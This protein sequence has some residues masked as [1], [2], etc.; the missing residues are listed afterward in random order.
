MTGQKISIV[1]GANNGIGFETAIGMA[2]AGFTVILACRNEAKALAA[3]EK[4]R[5]R[6]P[7][8]Q[9]DVILLDLS[10]FDSV[11]AFADAFGKKYDHLDV[12]INNA[13]VLDYSGRTNNAGIELQFAT[14]HLGHFLLT[15]L[16]LPLM[17]DRPASRIVSLSSVAHKAG[18][19][20]FDDIQCQGQSRK[21]AA[22][23][24]SKL[25]CLMFADELAR[26]LQKSG[27]KIYSLCAHPGGSDSG[28]FEDMARLH[29]Y[30]LKALGPFITHSNAQAAKPSL[31]AALAETAQ[32]GDY[33][34][35]QGF[36]EL[37][38]PVGPAMRT[39][40]AQDEKIAA[41]L[42]AL[43]ERMIGQ[44]FMR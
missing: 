5:A 19:I 16:L 10:D 17:P 11:R 35:P 4:I 28:L 38:G 3:K 40:Y 33:V 14:N 26:R 25:A 24:Q 43:S 12:L 1:T 15:S 9:R 21:G 6:L 23:E 8:A 22:Y 36:L 20:H 31:H 42:W 34:G 30:F 39:D 2:A 13:G 41:D 27:A 18:K 44:P 37:K 29:Y 32:N 7:Q